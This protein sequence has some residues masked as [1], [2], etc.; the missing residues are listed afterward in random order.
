MRKT[1]L[2][3]VALAPLV[4]VLAEGRAA[5]QDNVTSSLS[6]PIAT[7]TAN[8]GAPEDIVI[9]TGGSVSVSGATPAVTLN[10]SNNVTNEGAISIKDVTT[11]TATAPTTGVLLQGGDTGSLSNSGSI[12]VNE[13]YAATDTVNKDG[14]VEA[15]F[16]QGLYRD[17][18]RLTGSSS[19]VGSIT[20]SGS[21]AI[22]GKNSYGISIEAPL[23]GSLV[24]SGTISLT[25]EN[26]AGIRSTAGS[27]IGGSVT[28]TGGVS[29]LGQGSSAISLLGDVSGG[30]SLYSGV[31]ATGY[32]TVTRPTS[33]SELT[34]IQATSTDVE[35]SGSAVAIGGNVGKGIFI[36][37]APVGTDTTTSS[38]TDK[39]GDGIADYAEASGA[40]TSYGDAPALQIGS[41]ANITIGNFV[42]VN[43]GADTSTNVPN[44]TTADDYGLIVRGSVSADGIY[45]GVTATALQIGGVADPVS[46]VI[47]T[48]NMSGG[49]RVVGSITAT[50]YDANA[51][52]I[53]IGSGATVAEVRN[54]GFIQTTIDHSILDTTGNNATANTAYGILIDKGASVPKITNY[55]FLTAAATGDNASAVAIVDHSNSVTS[56]DNQ[57]EIVATITPGIAGDAT[58]GKTTAID[59]SGN[60][61]GVTLTQEANPNPI[62]VDVEITTSSSGVTTTTSATTSSTSGTT[63]TATSSTTAATTTT[64][65]TTTASG[66]TTTTVSTTPSTPSIVG[67]VFLGS[68]TNSVQLMAGSMVGALDLGSGANGEN[69]TFQVGSS[70]TAATYEGALTYGGTGLTLSVVNGSLVNTSPTT[71][72]LSS[73]SVGSTGLLYAAIDPANGKST[74]YDASSGTATLASGARLGIV[75]QSVLPGVETYTVIQAGTLSNANAD[76]VVLG[77]VPYILNATATTNATAGTIDITLSNKTSAQLGLNPG[78]SAAL[79]PVLTSLGNDAGIQAELL[80][81]DSRSGF[82]G[83]YDQLLPDYSGGVFQMASAASDA[84]TRATSRTN[85]IENP[86]G[87]RGA[88]AQEFAFGVDRSRSNAAGYEGAGFGFV[89]G[90][91]TGGAGFGAFGLTGAFVAGTLRDPHLPGSS[92]Q[93]ISEGEFGGYWQA[94]LGGFRADARLAGGYLYY[95]DRRELYEADAATGQITLDRNAK[96]SG[97]GYSATGHFGA[98]YQF[99]LGKWYIRPAA[100]ADYFKLYEGGFTEHGGGGVSGSSANSNDGFDLTLAARNGNQASGM[101]AV[102]VGGAF[103]TGFV[104][105]PEV[106]LGF[107][108]V[109]T[110]TSGDTTAR[111]QGGQNFTLTPPSITGGGP[112]ARFGLKGDTDFY[113]LDFQA[114]AEERNRF[115]EA[116]V[117]LNVRVLF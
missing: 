83:V 33:E 71:L 8:N 1:L 17:G 52:A 59:L 4:L 102:A 55:G 12:T 101:A 44:P 31:S 35:Q 5:A 13:S 24:N 106:Q 95:S 104:F 48:V 46:G 105:R 65:V 51:N 81:Q 58:S 32:S 111:F 56:I 37:A 7:A 26:G 91:E 54:E 113:E 116:D 25:G 103:G 85:E 29:A 39:D 21:I 90:L 115:T 79:S 84:I 68:G 2:A 72:N 75:L 82:L 67:D 96:G 30:V 18:V 97:T 50:A 45:D 38:T 47:G 70:S 110:G 78:E 69:S 93:S 89:G 23:T 61:A 108:D 114:G 14:V 15:P 100:Q 109:F 19:L 11:G 63:V 86:S 9:E 87:T 57:G 92:Q 77:A 6:T 64:T 10:S 40:I 28:L 43:G 107:R 74:L 98:A 76:S 117:R 22:Q 49:V 99:D 36:A 94:Q 3:A 27:T 53:H 88:W 20:N 80:G 42:G 66:V 112:V 16:A 62:P 34:N 60:T 41:G 73:L